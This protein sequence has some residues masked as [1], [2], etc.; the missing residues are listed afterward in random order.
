MHHEFYMKNALNLARRGVGRTAPNPS[1]GC[2]IVKN[3]SIISR[4]ATGKG[5]RP[6]AER[7]ALDIAG[8]EAENAISYVTLEPCAHYG[9]TPPCAEALIKARGAEVVIACADPDT[10]VNGKGMKMLR[11]A[12]IKVTF[13]VCEK[14][15]LELN[16]GF[17]KR[18]KTGLPFVTLKAAIS[19]DGKYAEGKGKPTWV[20]GEL[21]RNYVHL[22]RSQNEIIITGTGTVI[23]D[24][25]QLNVRLNGMEDCSPQVIVV[26][27]S[28]VNLQ[29]NWQQKNGNLKEILQQL[30]EQGFNNVMVEAGP[31]LSNAFIKAGLA[32]ELVIIQSPEELGKKGRDYFAQDALSKLTQVSE[33]TIGE[34]KISFLRFPPTRE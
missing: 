33:K 18:I 20:T 1:V 6:H 31:T 22:L 2:V 9:K 34:D 8:R 16:R 7:V 15:A 10:R 32:D 5:G 21:A 13:G 28:K 29:K 3:G 14:E 19:A 11:D 30:A 24:K 4:A 26:G 25:P 17:F 27:K 23:A 12:G